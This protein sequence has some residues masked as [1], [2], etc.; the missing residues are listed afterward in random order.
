MASWTL[1][2][3]S[4]IA[5]RHPYTFYKPDAETIDRVAAG[6]SVKL[7]FAFDTDNPDAPRAERLWVTVEGI[8][9]D[10]AFSGRLDNYPQYIRDLSLG[11]RIVFEA[12]HIINTEHDPR[13][14]PISRYARRCFVTRRVIDEEGGRLPLPRGAGRGKRQRLAA[15]GRRRVGRLHEYRRDHR[16]RQPG[17]G[18]ERRRQHPAA[19]RRA[20]GT[21][22]RAAGRRFLHRGAG[23]GGLSLSLAARRGSAPGARPGPGSRRDCGC[24]PSFP[25]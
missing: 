24:C 17:L 5:V 1:V 18:A 8:E 13:E 10:G 25:T 3:A 23:T 7:I 15:D 16:L 4:A 19:A 12:R 20:A 2:D 22:V 6:E 11:E 14:T 21:G 9:A